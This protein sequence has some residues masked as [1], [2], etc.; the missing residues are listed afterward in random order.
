MKKIIILIFTFLTFSGFSQN[1]DPAIDSFLKGQTGCCFTSGGADT[2]S[3]SISGNVL[4]ISRGNSVTLP[5]SGIYTI[6]VDSVSSNA[7]GDSLIVFKNGVRKSYK[8]PTSGSSTIAMDTQKIV[9]DTNGTVNNTI[10]ASKIG[11]TTNYVIKSDLPISSTTPNGLNNGLTYNASLGGWYVEALESA[12]VKMSIPPG[13][14]QSVSNGVQQTR[15]NVT[16]VTQVGNTTLL[17]P[18]LTNN[19]VRL[20]AGYDYEFS[21]YIPSE[22]GANTN[23]MSFQFVRSTSNTGTGTQFQTA[24][25]IFPMNAPSLFFQNSIPNGIYSPTVD[26]WIWLSCINS[27]GTNKINTP[28][29]VGNTGVSWTVKMIGKSY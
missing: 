16:A 21:A 2:Q 15:V 28:T 3:L 1:L 9:T 13:T 25:T 8:Y 27:V 10:I 22:F 14:Q 23:S 5:T 11:N 20:K 24:A 4:T 6:Y 12:V 17:T 19:S 18:D 26:T 29:G 7:V